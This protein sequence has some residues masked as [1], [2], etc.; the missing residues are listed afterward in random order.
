M[1]DYKD[2]DVITVNG[3][4]HRIESGAL[5][6]VA[7][8]GPLG[9][10]LKLITG[11]NNCDFLSE[12]YDVYLRLDGVGA[13]DGETR[14]ARY[15]YAQSD[16]LPKIM[17]VPIDAICELI[18]PRPTFTPMTAGEAAKVPGIVGRWVAVQVLKAEPPGR[19]GAPLATVGASTPTWHDSEDKILLIEGVDLP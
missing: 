9:G 10:E 15:N 12:E 19:S 7:G 18:P 11:L 5:V 4:P 3:K 8:K 13:V 1:T 17:H 16:Y 2:G 6:P 14:R